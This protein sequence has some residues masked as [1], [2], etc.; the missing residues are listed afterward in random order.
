M[1]NIG[2]FAAQARR[3]APLVV[4]LRLFRLQHF[5]CPCRTHWRSS[6]MSSA[7]TPSAGGRP[8]SSTTSPPVAIA[9]C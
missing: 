5:R 8:R 4:R 2:E 3:P 6:R 1:R 7:T 9:W